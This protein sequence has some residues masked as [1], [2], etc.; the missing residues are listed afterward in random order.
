MGESDCPFSCTSKNKDGCYDELFEEDG[1]WELS[2]PRLPTH[3][4]GHSLAENL[5]I[6]GNELSYSFIPFGVLEDAG[7]DQKGEEFFR[8]ATTYPVTR[9]AD[10]HPAACAPPYRRTRRIGDLPQEE[11]EAGNEQVAVLQAEVGGG[12]KSAVAAHRT[13]RVLAHLPHILKSA[14]HDK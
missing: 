7:D 13:S 8:P 2:D 5:F 11:W 9:I 1:V 3:K 12:I 14:F 6:A 4:T 10:R